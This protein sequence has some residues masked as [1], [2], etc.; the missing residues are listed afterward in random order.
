MIE[1]FSRKLDY[2][3]TIET[4]LTPIY[5]NDNVISLSAILLDDNYY[6]LLKIGKV[7]IN[8]ISVLALAYLDLTNRKQNG[9]IIDTKSIKKHQNDVIRL[10]ANIELGTKIY[11]SPVIMNDLSLFIEK[12]N[13]TKEQL[14]QLGL[15]KSNP[16]KIIQIIKT[17][18]IQK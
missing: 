7:E 3:K 9:E 2:L 14:K 15:L 6:D 8:D 16:E 5:I 18:Y 13:M 1:L 12:I 4:R 11:V 10:V 17:T